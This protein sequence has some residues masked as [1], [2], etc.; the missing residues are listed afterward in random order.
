MSCVVSH[1]A[2]ASAAQVSCAPASSR[3]AHHQNA[4][5]SRAFRKT[6]GGLHRVSSSRGSAHTTRAL[7]SFLDGFTNPLFGGGSGAVA[8]R[9]VAKQNLLD[10]IAGCDRGEFY[11][12]ALERL[13]PNKKTLACDLINGEWEL[14]YTT[15][16]AILGATRPWPFRPSGKIYQTIDVPRNRARNRET[17]PF[18]NAVDADLTP[19]SQ[20]NVD[21]QFVKFE[22][23]GIL[24]VDAPE[25]AKGALNTTYVDN[26]IR[27]SRGDKGNLF[28]LRMADATKELFRKGD[29]A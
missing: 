20:S 22:I 8:K 5:T 6:G 28:V 26:E 23:F 16:K 7:P 19:T 25:S 18:F 9:E 1:A 21:V 2:C 15:S 17:F 29:E 24:K 4:S 13:N 27:V 11:A 12:S 14:L 10:A 3:R